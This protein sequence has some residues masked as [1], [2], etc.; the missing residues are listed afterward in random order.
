[1]GEG[2]GEGIF[3]FLQNSSDMDQ[4]VGMRVAR[5]G[6]SSRYIYFI[7]FRRPSLSHETSDEV[8]CAKRAVKAKT[9]AR[10]KALQQTTFKDRDGHQLPGFHPSDHCNVF[11]HRRAIEQVEQHTPPLLQGRINA[12]HTCHKESWKQMVHPQQSNATKTLCGLSN[13]ISQQ[14]RSGYRNTLFP[15]VYCLL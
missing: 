8:I 1:M 11:L 13:F 5:G 3:F 12:H 6:W 9:K 15:S 7:Y 4:L 2:E 14:P 10:I